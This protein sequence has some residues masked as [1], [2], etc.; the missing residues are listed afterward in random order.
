MN[1][2]RI[3]A[4]R[5]APMQSDLNANG[6]IFGGWIMAQMDIAGG[7]AGIKYCDGPVA[8]VA[9]EGMQFHQPVL[10]GD[11][12]NVYADVV[13]VGTTSMTIHIEVTVERRGHDQQI[14]VTEGVFVFVALDDNHQPKVIQK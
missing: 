10:P 13:N 6:H 12:L 5:T 9:V 3:P 2:A 1:Q 14:K 4:L 8:T 7:Y 11:W